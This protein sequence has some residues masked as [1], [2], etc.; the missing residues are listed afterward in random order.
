VFKVVVVSD[1]RSVIP[2]KAGTHLLPNN[3][4]IPA[5]AGIHLLPN[6]FLLPSHPETHNL[7]PRFRGDDEPWG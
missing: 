3:S 5:K 2:A 1:C 4:V 7:D 6:N